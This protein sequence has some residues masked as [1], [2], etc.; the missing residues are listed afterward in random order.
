VGAAAPALADD[1]VAYSATI[2]LGVGSVTPKIYINKNC[3]IEFPNTVIPVKESF[4]SFFFY[5]I[6]LIEQRYI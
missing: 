4:L 1:L 5:K 6:I 2:V 3:F